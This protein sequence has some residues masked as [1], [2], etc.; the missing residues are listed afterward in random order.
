MHF[1]FYKAGTTVPF[2]PHACFPLR[3]GLVT[4]MRTDHSK[5]LGCSP[6]NCERRSDLGNRSALQIRRSRVASFRRVEPSGVYTLR[7]RGAWIPGGHPRAPRQKSTSAGRSPVD[8]NKHSRRETASTHLTKRATRLPPFG[9]FSTSKLEN[10]PII[11]STIFSL[12]KR[13]ANSSGKN[14]RAMKSL[15]GRSASVRGG[16]CICPRRRAWIRPRTR[17]RVPD[18]TRI[19]TPSQAA[20]R[21]RARSATHKHTFEARPDVPVHR[22]AC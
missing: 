14:E 5:G 1:F 10:R 9:T 8:K 15:K 13:S 7:Q 4:H 20:W 12:W 22:S 18:G 16:F 2:D 6:Q 3:V 21:A 11:P 19:S 17:F